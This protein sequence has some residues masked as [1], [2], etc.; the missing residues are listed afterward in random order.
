MNQG[1]QMT[2]KMISYPFAAVLFDMDGVIID[3]T[4]LHQLVWREFAHSHGLN[5]SEADIQATNGRRAIDVVLSLFGSIADTQ[6]LQLAA[7]RGALYRQ[8]L[9]S[10]DIQPV[11]GVKSFLEK[12]GALGVPRILATSARLDNVTL[13]LSRLELSRYFEDIVSASDVCNGKPHPEVY[14]TAAK[15]AAVN[16]QDC[17]V[18]ED[19]LPGIQ[20][21]K[22]ADAFCLGMTTS[23]SEE[24]LKQVGADWVAPDFYCLPN[25]LQIA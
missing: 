2:N 9:A 10:T 18:I 4:P 1:L 12:L 25:Q 11:S 14:L 3:N 24:S 8:Y 7:A 16:P 6:V 19:S 23:Q 21:A 20:A 15:R 13:V 22:A 17:L 5:P